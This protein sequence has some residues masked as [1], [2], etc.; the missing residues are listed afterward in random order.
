MATDKEVLEH[1]F[2]KVLELEEA[3]IKFLR[4]EG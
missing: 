2:V 3:N 4:K 1:L